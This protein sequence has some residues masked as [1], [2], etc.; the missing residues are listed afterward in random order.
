MARCHNTLIRPNGTPP[1]A[2]AA[3]VPQPLVTRLRCLCPV[4]RGTDCETKSPVLVRRGQEC[5]VSSLMAEYL[6]ATFPQGFEEV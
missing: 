1:P 2:L 3:Q 4:Y 6:L 5:E